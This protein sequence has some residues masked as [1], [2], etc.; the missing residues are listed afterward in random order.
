[1]Q[2]NAQMSNITLRGAT[3]D[4]FRAIVDFDGA[5]FGEAWKADELDLLRPTLEL[6]RFIL[7]HDGDDLV[8]VSGNYSFELTVPGPRVLRVAGVTW[9]AVSPTHRRQGLLTRMMN[10]LH[11]DA[12][13]HDEPLAILTA[14]E[15]AIYR[16]F[17][18]G[19]ASQCR[20]IEI[21]RR[22]TEVLPEFRPQPGEV[23]FADATNDDVLEQI[24]ALFDRIRRERIGDIDRPA[25]NWKLTRHHRSEGTRWAVHADGF[26]CWKVTAKWNNGHPAHEMEL[27]DLVAATPE[28]HAALW[29]TVLSVDL[30]GP[31]RSFRAAAIDDHLPH[32]VTDPRALRTVDL[33][34]MLWVHVRDARAALAARTY[35]NDDSLVIE[36]DGSRWKVDGSPEGAVVK[37]AK[38]TPDLVMDGAALGSIYLGGFRPSEL[39][40][41]RRIE[42]RNSDVLRRSDRF[43]AADQM[44]HTSSGF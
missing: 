35:G 25:A 44:P 18:Y 11:A 42:A 10:E 37:P 19:I 41:G 8:G 3:D 1:M 28:A 34:D 12:D 6:D 2:H 5:V 14:S 36:V 33:N 29:H 20:V 27:F 15:G 16:R 9:V 38:R 26:A 32:I 17:G 43:F 24:A 31:I 23:R 22:R 21:D 39:V 30:V 4:D 40:R 7:A 13:A